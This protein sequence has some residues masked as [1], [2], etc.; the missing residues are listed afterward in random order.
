MQKLKRRFSILGSQ[1][2]QTS[3]PSQNNKNYQAVTKQSI[4]TR[5]CIHIFTLMKYYSNVTTLLSKKILNKTYF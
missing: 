5:I 4:L 3:Y 2:P 1:V